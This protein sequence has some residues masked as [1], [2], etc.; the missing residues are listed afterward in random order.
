MCYEIRWFDENKSIVYAYFPSNT[1]W[2]DY[3]D[4]GTTFQQ[5]AQENPNKLI[6]LI[7]DILEAP[8]RIPPNLFTELRHFVNDG[9]VNI[10]NWGMTIIIDRIGHQQLLSSVLFFLKIFTNK[11]S[12][13]T[14]L[15]EAVQI[16]KAH[17]NTFLYSRVH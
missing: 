17:K 9:Q 2:E 5:L 15:D 6:F 8:F 11:F 1:T 13:A 12:S 14:T 16:I 7:I 3:L 10:P 4:C